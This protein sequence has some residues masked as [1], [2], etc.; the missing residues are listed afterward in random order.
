MVRTQVLRMWWAGCHA[1]S[2]SHLCEFSGPSPPPE[3]HGGQR[4]VAV[5]EPQSL[6]FPTGDVGSEGPFQPGGLGLSRTLSPMLLLSPGTL[7]AVL[8]EHSDSESDEP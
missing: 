1:P 7:C 5:G 8:G 6:C 3:L 4:W 2:P